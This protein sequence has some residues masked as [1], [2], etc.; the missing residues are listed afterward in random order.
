MKTYREALWK[1]PVRWTVFVIAAILT[2]L[3]I[4]TADVFQRMGKVPPAH[5][6]WPLGVGALLGLLAFAALCPQSSTERE[7]HRLVRQARRQRPEPIEQPKGHRIT[8][9]VN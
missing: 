5:T 4:R 2:A 7:H 6:Y 8:G 3:T 1:K 9:P